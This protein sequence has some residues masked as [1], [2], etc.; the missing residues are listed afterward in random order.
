MTKF[1]SHCKISSKKLKYQ[2]KIIISI[3][4]N[5]PGKQQKLCRPMKR[6]VD[7]IKTAGRICSSPKKTGKDISLAVEN[8][9]FMMNNI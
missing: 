5:A 9:R 6:W 3:K 4:I 8:L 7:N 2:K 1:E